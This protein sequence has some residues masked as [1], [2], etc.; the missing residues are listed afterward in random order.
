MEWIVIDDGEDCVGD[1]FKDVPN[2]KYTRLEKKMKLG[3]KRNFMH[4][5]CKGD[6]IVYMD[7]DDFYH[8][9]RVNHAVNKLRGNPKALCSGSSIIHIYFKHIETI[10]EFGPYGPRHATAG[11]FAFKRELL[12]LTRYDD[13]ADMA[14]EKKFLKDYTIPFVQLN[15][16]K[17]M[18]V[19]THDENTFDKKIL[20]ERGENDFMRKTSL[21]VKAFIKDKKMR[22]FYVTQ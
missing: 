15:P 1:L 22:D 18:L 17:T 3:A 19:F 6:I 16:R 8:P 11:T 2:V 9:E 20:L 12:K 5:K 4:T 10:Y 21:K 14:E 7:D 13:D